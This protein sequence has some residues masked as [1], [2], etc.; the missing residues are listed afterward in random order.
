[1]DA[2]VTKDAEKMLCTLYKAYLERR[3]SGAPKQSARRF[4]AAYFP[5][6]EPFASMDYRDVDDA[7]LELSRKG[8]LRVILGGD[9]DITD[10]ALVYLDNR[11]KDGLVSVISFLA[12]F[13]Q[14]W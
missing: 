4:E 11:F 7:K 2:I 14:K 3:K 8:L 1:M 9:C 12:Q 13:I 6:T 10:D 5:T